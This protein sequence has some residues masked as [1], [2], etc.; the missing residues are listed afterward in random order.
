M[1]PPVLIWRVMVVA[2]LWHARSLVQLLQLRLRSM[3]CATFEFELTPTEQIHSIRLIHSI[4]SFMLVH[5]Y[6]SVRP[7]H[8]AQLAWANVGIPTQACM[9]FIHLAPAYS[10]TC[11]HPPQVHRALNRSPSVRRKVRAVQG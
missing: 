10:H 4:H 9:L 11:I 1:R 8:H 6:D 3:E 2:K 5:T 7:S